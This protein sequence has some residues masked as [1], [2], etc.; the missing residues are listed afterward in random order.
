MKD[1]VKHPDSLGNLTKRHA[2]PRVLNTGYLNFVLGHGCPSGEGRGHVLTCQ[3]LSCSVTVG[4]N[5]TLFGE[6]HF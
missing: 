5:G 4:K 2:T 3:I 1:M 6:D